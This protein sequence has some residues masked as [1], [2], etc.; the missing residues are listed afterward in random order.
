MEG[1]R[2]RS[3]CKRSRHSCSGRLPCS[4]HAPLPSARRSSQATKAGATQ[5]PIAILGGI[6][7]D[8]SLG[9]LVT[10][11]GAFTA[12]SVLLKYSRTAE[13]QADVL[14]TQILYDAGYDPRALA[15]FFEKLQAQGGP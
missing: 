10:Q 4:S 7:G 1:Q 2:R 8:S 11:L 13:T 6:L 12:G 9:A 15:Q 5:L 3:V 14:G